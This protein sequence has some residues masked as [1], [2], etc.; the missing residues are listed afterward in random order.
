LA[1]GE[2]VD[3]DRSHMKRRRQLAIRV[4][5]PLLGA[6]RVILSI[7]STSLYSYRANQAG[8]LTLSETLLNGL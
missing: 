5:V 4:D 3:I 7:P 8:G 6:A 1:A 2:I